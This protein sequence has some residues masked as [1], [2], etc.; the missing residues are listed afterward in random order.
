MILPFHAVII[1]GVMLHQ[2]LGSASP[3]DS[4]TSSTFSRGNG[5]LT[6]TRGSPTT[7]FN[8]ISTIEPV[9]MPSSGSPDSVLSITPV[10]APMA[11]SEHKPHVESYVGNPSSPA[12]PQ[13][14]LKNDAAEGVTVPVSAKW[15]GLWKRNGEASPNA[16]TRDA[17]VDTQKEYRPQGDP[18]NTYPNSAVSMSKM[19][20]PVLVATMIAWAVLFVFSCATG[21]AAAEI[22]KEPFGNTTQ[23]RGGPGA[24]AAGGVAGGTAHGHGSG[25]HSAGSPTKMVPHMGFLLLIAVFWLL[26]ICATS[27]PLAGA[28][29]IPTNTHQDIRET[30][31]RKVVVLMGGWLLGLATVL[32]GVFYS[33]VS[34]A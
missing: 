16:P 30:W 22:S 4:T 24:G 17:V 2:G 21:A 6:V 10:S 1:L 27:L 7:N 26:G 5:I 31:V 23:H 20:F 19:H 13:S 14:P 9:S 3:I 18:F 11:T 32:S 12:I 33:A 34:A 25:N 8:H 15:R 29:R 28:A